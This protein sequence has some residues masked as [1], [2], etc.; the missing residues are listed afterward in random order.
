MLATV[1]DANGNKYDSN[2]R[3]AKYS[4]DA[5]NSR[6][7]RNGITRNGRDASQ[8][9]QTRQQRRELTAMAEISSNSS[10][11]S[12]NG[13]TDSNRNDINLKSFAEIHS[14]I[15]QMAKN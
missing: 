1:K 8:H 6:D 9:Q 13:N 5:I 7:I 2:S 4:K 14:R 3:E 10:N 11:A 12:N 15:V